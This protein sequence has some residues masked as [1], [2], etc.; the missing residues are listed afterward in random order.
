[1][2]MLSPDEALYA[3]LCKYLLKEADATEQ[4]WVNNWLQADPAHP[5]LLASLDKLLRTAPGQTVAG[6]MDTDTAWQL[7]SSRMEQPGLKKVRSMRTW[8][9]SAAAAV[10]LLAGAGL[11]YMNQERTIYYSGAQLVILRDGT[12]IQLENAAQLQV[13]P[14]FGKQNR[15]VILK[16]KAD[17]DV[18]TDAAHPFIIDLGN[19]AITVLGTRFSVDNSSHLRVFINS[20]KIKVTRQQDSVVLTAGMLLQEDSTQHQFQV[21]A[22]ITDAEAHAVVFKDTPLRE[23]LQT[24]SV[25]YHTDL[26]ADEE[27]LDLPVTATYTGE[28]VQNVLDAIAFMTNATLEKNEAGYI[29]KSQN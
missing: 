17:F 1:M 25:L 21:G 7:L 18:T 2:T 3:L 23:V 10:V 11:W 27:L 14:G 29:L 4:Q 20:G 16:G 13:L 28:P 8:W 9:M 12:S 22:H 19:Q 5:V 6:G 24:I 26:H 15:K